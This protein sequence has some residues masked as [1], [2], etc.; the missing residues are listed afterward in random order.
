M[1][2]NEVYSNILFSCSPDDGLRGQPTVRWDLLHRPGKTLTVRYDDSGQTFSVVENATGRTFL[3]NG[4]LDGVVVDAKVRNRRIVLRQADG[5]IVTLELSGDT[6]F[7]F[8]RKELRNPGA[9]TTDI[10]RVVP[11]TFTLDLGLKP[12]E[13]RTMGTAGLTARI[14]IPGATC[15]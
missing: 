10:Q 4:K 14:S 11:V 15:S 9:S 6:P 8:I 13:L 3:G 1:F 12:A 2:I 5:S 7:L